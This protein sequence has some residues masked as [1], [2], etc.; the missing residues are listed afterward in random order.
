MSRLKFVIFPSTCNNY[1]DNNYT[2]VYS[3]VGV[4]DRFY[5][6]RSAQ[7]ATIPTT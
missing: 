6:I 7:L 5:I 3:K 1:M 2:N 4:D